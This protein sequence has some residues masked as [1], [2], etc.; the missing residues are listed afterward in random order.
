MFQ[1]QQGEAFFSMGA[2]THDIDVNAPLSAVYNQWT[3]FEDFPHFME[4]VKEV[5]QDGDK[6]LFW[7]ATIGGKEK[8]W[9]AEIVEQV[10]D[11]HIV[12]R[13]IEGAPNRGEVTFQALDAQRTKVAL[14]IDYESE[15]LVEKVG[16]AL[17]IASGRVEGDL[18]RFR[19]FIEERGSETGGWR[20]QVG[21][22]GNSTT[23]SD[24]TRSEEEL[25]SGREPKS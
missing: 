6:R 1:K 3:Q 25:T 13:S 22:E 8:E 17:G 5:R 7:R 15:G 21:G 2:I 19:D 16:D 18:K 20:G 14:T 4:G 10:P 12:W 11:S 9:H 24:S 23:T